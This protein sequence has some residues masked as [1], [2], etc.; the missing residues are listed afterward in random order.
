MEELGEVLRNPESRGTNR[1]NSPRPWGLPETELKGIY[2]LDLGPC[3]Y[4]TDMQI[5]LHVGS[6]TTGGGAYPDSV[7]CWP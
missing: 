1:V 6:P 3:T 2:G 7:A 4:V 5:G